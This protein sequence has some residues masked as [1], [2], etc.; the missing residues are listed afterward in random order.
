MNI[1]KIIQYK[2]Y[3]IYT[4]LLI[5]MIYFL[6]FSYSKY[7]VSQ[8]Q[9]QKLKNS[10]VILQNK[11]NQDVSMYKEKQTY[12]KSIVYIK[13]TL[14]T[15]L[16]LINWVRQENIMAN[17]AGVRNQITFANAL[18]SPNN[19]TIVGSTTKTVPQILAVTI[20]LQ[21]SFSNILEFIKMVEN[22]YYFTNIESIAINSQTGVNYLN[23]SISLNLYVQ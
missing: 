13:N 12:Q 23:A 17:L 19:I 2:D 14:P 16:S 6:S 20:D 15:N 8:N 22:S 21:G 18:L 7:S 4:I 10:I 9:K 5:A 11:A 1:S 3:L